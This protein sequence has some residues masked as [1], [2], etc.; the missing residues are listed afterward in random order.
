MIEEI[1]VSISSLQFQLF[2]ETGSTASSLQITA[3][4]S[5]ATKASAADAVLVDLSAA[6]LNKG[7]IEAV[8]ADLEKAIGGT[9]TSGSNELTGD[10]YE[11]AISEF[12]MLVEGNLL[13]ET[14]LTK[15][16]ALTSIKVTLTE[17]QITKLKIVQTSFTVVITK[18]TTMITVIQA[19]FKE[20]TGTD[21][22]AIQIS[23]GSSSVTEAKAASTTFMKAL[24]SLTVNKGSIEKVETALTSAAAGTLDAGSEVTSAVFL[25]RLTAFFALLEEDYSSESITAMSFDIINV[26]VTLTTAEITQVTTLKSSISLILIKIS[27]AIT[28]FQ[29][30]VK[31]L[32]GAEATETQILAGDA[33]ATVASVKEESVMQ[34]KVMTINIDSVEKVSILIESIMK[35]AVTAT[36]SGTTEMTNKE[37]FK[38]LMMFFKAISGDFHSEEV[39]ALGAQLSSAKLSTAL[40]TIEMTDIQL[41][42][43]KL[44]V[45]IIDI[46]ITI[47]VIQY[48][49]IVMTGSAPMIDVKDA[50]ADAVEDSIIMLK[51]VSKNTKACES[52]EKKLSEAIGGTATTGAETDSA[53]FITIVETFIKLVSA[54][55]VDMT[56]V[57][58]STSITTAKVTLTAAQITTITTFKTS[59]TELIVKLKAKTSE[60]QEKIKS[61]VSSTANPAQIATGSSNGNKDTAVMET[62]MELKALTLTSAAVTQVSKTIT[63]VIAGSATTGTEI[64]GANFIIIVK[65]FLSVTKISFISV[66]ITSLALTIATSKVTLTAEEQTTIKAVQVILI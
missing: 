31:A 33:S 30:Q 18:I 43:T 11:T 4:S 29:S 57:T 61:L 58:Q 24:K 42:S 27:V 13:D 15:S 12:L 39:T 62:L 2:S 40:T 36:A 51:I 5:D 25:E 64:T 44:E 6:T 38:L 35:D 7:A 56:I 26:K 28:F 60:L 48:Q 1:T 53:T 9:A 32:T 49:L 23:A 52:V 3:G 10:A 63:S 14:I 50:I 65:E 47:Q 55:L 34:L 21:A 46:Q 37:F 17:T 16:Y 66:K 45:L 59:L 8:I 41:I 20:I 22:T 54:D 19:T